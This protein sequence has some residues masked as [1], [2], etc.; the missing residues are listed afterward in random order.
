MAGQRPG[1]L[2]SG[3]HMHLTLTT[4]AALEPL[5]LAEAKLHLRLDEGAD[6]AGLASL[7]ASARLHVERSH[8]LALIA[9]G[10]TL[11]LD[12]WPRTPHIVLPLWPVIAV[13][14]VKV[15]G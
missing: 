5:T 10:W 12:D 8:G 2:I 7:I 4:P 14:A 15:L 11:H 13:T 6:D 1:H 3:D 9:Q